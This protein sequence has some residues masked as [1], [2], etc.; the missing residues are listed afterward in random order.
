LVDFGYHAPTAWRAPTSEW[1][2]N[3]R[4]QSRGWQ[5]GSRDHRARGPRTGQ[6]GQPHDR[7]PHRHPRREPR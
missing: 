7:L 6:G 3:P 2:A 4:Q 5:P 1:A